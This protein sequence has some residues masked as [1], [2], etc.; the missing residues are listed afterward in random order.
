MALILA[1]E[2]TILAKY[3]DFAYVFLE[4]LANVLSK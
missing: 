2:V 4:K 3:L 1:K